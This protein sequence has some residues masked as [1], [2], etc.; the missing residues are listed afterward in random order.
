MLTQSDDCCAAEISDLFTFEFKG[1][2]STHC[3]PLIFTTHTGKQNQHGWLEMIEALWHRKPLICML[4]GLVFYLLCH[5]NLGDE[6]FSDL[7]KW[8]AWYKIHLIKSSI[9]TAAFFYNSQR[10][11]VA[12]AFKY[13]GI[14]SKKKIHIDQS[15][16]AKL[17][18]LKRISENQIWCADRWNQKQMID[19]YLNSLLWKFMRAMADYALQMEC[20]EISHAAI[21]L[22]DT[23]LSMIWPQLN[24]WKSCF[25]SQKGQINDLAAAGLVD[26]LL[27]LREIILQNSMTL[28]ECFSDHSIWNH[29]VFQHEAYTAFSQKMQACQNAEKEMP[30]QL[31]VLY[32]AIS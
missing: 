19:C 24:T 7:T 26:L 2:G 13:T 3:M 17:A 4:S 14:L 31:S 27:Y 32:Q 25:G 18:E 6:A 5:W 10:K 23:L 11:W 16:T 30:N 15:S 21:V 1:E 28:H 22:P 29:P 8:S 9:S 20:F 12:R